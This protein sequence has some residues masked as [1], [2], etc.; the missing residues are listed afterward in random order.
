MPWPGADAL[1][2]EFDGD[3]P[4]ASSTHNRLACDIKILGPPFVIT[5]TSHNIF[6]LC[7]EQK[8]HSAREAA[9]ASLWPSAH[10]DNAVLARRKRC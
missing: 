8:E 7:V 9:N 1:M 6:V 5:T 10:G 2:A 3:T 4:V